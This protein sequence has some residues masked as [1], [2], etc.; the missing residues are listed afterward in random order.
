MVLYVIGTQIT[1][2]PY[3][4]SP[5]KNQ[6]SG[7]FWSYDSTPQPLVIIFPAFYTDN[8]CANRQDFSISLSQKP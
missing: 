6:L 1:M 3:L 4:I 2:E 5:R 8:S 7:N